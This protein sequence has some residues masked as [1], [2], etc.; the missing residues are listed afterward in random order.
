[1]SIQIKDS[2]V[3]EIFADYKQKQPQISEQ[4]LAEFRDVLELFY[5]VHDRY[6]RHGE[7]SLETSVKDLKRKLALYRKYQQII[8]SYCQKYQEVLLKEYILLAQFAWHWYEIVEAEEFLKLSAELW[9]FYNLRVKPARYDSNTQLSTFY[10]TPYPQFN[11]FYLGEL[12]IVQGKKL[13]AIQALS[14]FIELEPNFLPCQDFS[15][16][17]YFFYCNKELPSTLLARDYL[18]F[19]KIAEPIDGQLLLRTFFH[20]WKV[21]NSR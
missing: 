15:L 8:E 1:M 9:F 14:K 4:D 13:E 18:E 7:N 3:E 10:L 2:I 16:D 12:Y 6:V 5:V 20:D 17:H 19:L 11:Y 21:K